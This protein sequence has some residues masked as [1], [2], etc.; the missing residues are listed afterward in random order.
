MRTGKKDD[1]EFV[2]INSIIIKTFSRLLDKN[3]CKYKLKNC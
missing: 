3:Q 2:F 1:T